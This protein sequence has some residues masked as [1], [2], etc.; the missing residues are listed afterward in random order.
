M[1]RDHRYET[2]EQVHAAENNKAGWMTI[3]IA[4]KSHWAYHDAPYF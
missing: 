4:S 2:E 3:H 1:P